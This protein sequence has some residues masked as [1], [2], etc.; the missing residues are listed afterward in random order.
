M[1]CPSTGP[2]SGP[3]SLPAEFVSLRHAGH[4]LHADNPEGFI[5]VVEG[6]L[7]VRAGARG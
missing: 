6:F 2:P 4:W 3:C 1:C 5:A 7:R